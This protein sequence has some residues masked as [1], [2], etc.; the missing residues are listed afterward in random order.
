MAS[1]Q[2]II[3]QAYTKV[4]GEFEVVINGSDDWNTY[5]NVLNQVMQQW[6]TTPYVKWQSL[7]NT[8]YEVGTTST[9][10]S[11]ELDDFDRIVIGKTPFDY[12]FFTNGNAIV[13]KKQI[14]SQAKFQSGND[15][16]TAAILGDTLYLKEVS[17]AI[18]G[19]TI[20]LPVYMLP[21]TYTSANQE[22]AIDNV[23]WLI[24]SMAAFICDS[25][26]VP[27]IARNADKF[28]K[29]AETFMKTMKENNSHS[30]RLI[31]NSVAKG[32]PPYS[33]SSFIEAINSGIL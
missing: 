9:N 4:N 20:K 28:A 18:I 30:Q 13:D 26:P 27:F 31:I 2:D 1:V 29:Q 14:V 3:N 25:S 19:T 21:E 11:Y 33:Y 22:V 32:S 23:S 15:A 5:L 12:V 10:L 16:A 6:A 17:S 24:M 7:F 8:E